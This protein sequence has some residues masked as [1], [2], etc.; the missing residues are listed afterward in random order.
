MREKD[1]SWSDGAVMR[2]LLAHPGG[3]ELHIAARSHNG[4]VVCQG[5]RGSW[6]PNIAC[7]GNIPIHTGC[8]SMHA[9]ARHYSS[10]RTLGWHP[11]CNVHHVITG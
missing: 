8:C 2:S 3:L 6:P 10:E 11:E 9:L 4:Y 5:H 7:Q 1:M